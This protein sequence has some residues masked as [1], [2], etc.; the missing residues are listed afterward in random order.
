M[1][2]KKR[3]FA[4]LDEFFGTP[5]HHSLLTC[6]NETFGSQSFIYV[7]GRGRRPELEAFL[8]ARKF[9]VNPDYGPRGQIVEVQVSY[10]RGW[11][12]DI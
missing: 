7:A 11:N 2:S 12:W 9:K 1:K 5:G 4:A 3:L 6:G 8:T 10:F